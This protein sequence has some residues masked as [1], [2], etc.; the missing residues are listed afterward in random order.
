MSETQFRVKGIPSTFII[1]MLLNLGVLPS[2]QQ[3]H[4]RAV[5]SPCRESVKTMTEV[6]TC[7]TDKQAW[8][9]RARLKKCWDVPHNCSDTQLSYHCVLDEVGHSLVEVCALWTEIIGRKC[10][11]FNPGGM[12][13]QEHYENSCR[14]CPFVY[15]SSMGFLYGECFDFAVFQFT[16][17][18]SSTQ[19]QTEKGIIDM[20]NSTVKN[21]S[22][23]KEPT[24]DSLYYAVP[25]GVT[26]PFA[27]FGFLY[28]YYRYCSRQRDLKCAKTKAAE[29]LDSLNAQ[30]HPV[31]QDVE[32][33]ADINIDPTSSRTPLM[34]YTKGVDEGDDERI[35][36]LPSG[37]TLYSDTAEINTIP[38]STE[39]TPAIPL[40]EELNES[41]VQQC[42]HLLEILNQEIMDTTIKQSEHPDVASDKLQEQLVNKF[43]HS[44]IVP[45]TSE[46]LETLKEYLQHKR[47]LKIYINREKQ[48]QIEVMPP[49]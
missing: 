16:T 12:F 7:P 40:N 17:D 3:R 14:S 30:D 8:D 13:V 11:E 22:H 26:F 32:D 38:C 45:A 33:T 41:Q 1:F 46:S 21:F 34:L 24:A 49:E 5:K 19:Q 35:H 37:I 2:S 28:L 29:P 43:G 48:I 23:P 27:S 36:V 10:A 18:G 25:L 6:K 20:T 4:H 44:Y 39:E 15:N 42:Q 31:N 47:M 9:E